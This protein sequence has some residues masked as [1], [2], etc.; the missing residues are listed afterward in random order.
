MANL[1]EIRTR[2]SSVKSTQQI[3]SA[4]KMVAASKLRKAQSRILTLRPYARMQLELLQTLT[5]AAGAGNEKVFA[6]VR[7][8]EH[9]LIVVFSSNRGLSGAYNSNVLR[10]TNQLLSQYKEQ[11]SR[12]N[13]EIITV[14]KKATEFYTRKTNLPV[15]GSFD[16][17]YDTL[18]YDEVAAT[19]KNIINDFVTK[20]YDKILLVYH[21]FKNA[22]VQYL[23]V[24][25]F[26]PVMGTPPTDQKLNTE[27]EYIFDPSRDEIMQNLI[28]QVLK[29]Q[30]YKALSD[31]WASEQGARMTA[32]SQAT[33]N[34]TELL[35]DLR[36]AYNKARQASITKEILEIVSGAEALK[37]V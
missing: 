31:A 34:A 32:M 37:N 7:P 30:F 12:G 33:D 22:V 14:G 19:V 13:V 35:K 20:K 2:I 4:M 21:Q 3:T 26:L 9:I 1:K 28:P 29:T 27:V 5:E 23:K 6:E 10:Q 25:Q 15:V 11:V 18:S 16:H 36:M 24:E 8:E 17:F